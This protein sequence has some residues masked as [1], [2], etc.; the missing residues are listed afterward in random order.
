MNNQL[1]ESLKSIKTLEEEK[2]LLETKIKE[3]R[4]NVFNVLESENLAQYKTDI[5]TISYVERKTVKYD[6]K[7]EVLKTLEARN[8]VKYIEVIPEHKEINKDFEKDV[9]NGIE[10]FT[11][12]SVDVKKS[13]M[14]RFNK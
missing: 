1:E 12:V 9:K 11:G 8:L 10:E 4:Q 2:T 14:I 3:E 7:E 13:P 6:N 5:A